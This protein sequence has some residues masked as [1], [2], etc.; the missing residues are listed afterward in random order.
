MFYCYLIGILDSWQENSTAGA[1]RW[2]LHRRIA[3]GHR[4]AVDAGGLSVPP[5]RRD[6]VGLRRIQRHGC[7]TAGRCLETGM[8]LTT[9]WEMNR[10]CFVEN[11]YVCVFFFRYDFY[12]YIYIYIPFGNMSFWSDDVVTCWEKCLVLKWT[13]LETSILGACWRFVVEWCLAFLN[14]WSTD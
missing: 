12:V 4:V 13:N 11:V 7:G 9:H 3:A 1:T 6:A 10:V 8:A 2:R 14:S 5:A